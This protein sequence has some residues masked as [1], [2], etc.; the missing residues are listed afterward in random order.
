LPGRLRDA[1]VRAEQIGAI[2]AAAMRD[3]WVH[4]NP[5][6][7]PTQADVHSILQSAW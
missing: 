3:P 1:G 5:R 6:P 7:L 2:T 4:S